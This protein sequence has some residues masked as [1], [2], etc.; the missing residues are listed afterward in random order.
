[1]AGQL[2]GIGMTANGVIEYRH[3]IHIPLCV[4]IN[5][6]RLCVSFGMGKHL[7][8]NEGPC[9]GDLPSRGFQR[10]KTADGVLQIK[11]FDSFAIYGEGLTVTS[12]S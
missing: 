12:R 11:E 4:V 1:M 2:I 8:A 5:E 6:I 10:R 9:P 3:S 7:Y